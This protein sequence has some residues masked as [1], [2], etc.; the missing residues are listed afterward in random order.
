MWMFLRGKPKFKLKKINLIKTLK[1]TI[2]VLFL[3][4]VFSLG[5]TVYENIRANQAINAFKAR[6]VF[7]AEVQFESRPGQFQTRRYYSV[8][9]E[10]SYELADERSVFN[11]DRQYLGQKGDIFVTQ[12]SPFPHVFGIHQF[13][14]YYYGG[15]A[16]LHDGQNRFIEALGFPDEDESLL[17]I[18]LIRG[19]E[20]HTYSTTVGRNSTN[21]WLLVNYRGES[22]PEYPYYGGYYRPDF[23]G[24]RVK[25]ITEEQIDGAVDYAY[26]K[27]ENKAIYNF[28][29][30]LNMK[31]KYY[32]TDLVSRAYQSVMVPENKQHVYSRAL[33]DDRFITSVNDM[34]LSRETYIAF[35]VEIIE[36][37]LHI[38][39][40]EDVS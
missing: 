9:R 8:P 38:Y 21:Y 35:Y 14:S 13:I 15:H 19:D 29:F 3:A 5:F 30:F 33:N 10:T 22:S 34:I 27:Y 12:D 25:N 11:T 28:L 23:V 40:L 4:A 7:E 26:D 18:M 32:C 17:E 39:Y 1:R 24:L 20:P 6:A 16:A 36:D 37:V 31:Y 2:F